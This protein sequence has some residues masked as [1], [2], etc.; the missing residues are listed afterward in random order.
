MMNATLKKTGL[1][2]T[3][4]IITQ[5]PCPESDLLSATAQIVMQQRAGYIM[6]HFANELPPPAGDNHN[7]PC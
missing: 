5:S 3:S 2:G 6:G 7:P 4:N 1:L